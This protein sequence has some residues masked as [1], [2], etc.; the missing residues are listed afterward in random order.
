MKKYSPKTG[1][2]FPIGVGTYRLPYTGRK[3]DSPRDMVD[4]LPCSFSLKNDNG[5]MDVWTLKPWYTADGHTRRQ[6]KCKGV[7]IPGWRYERVLTYMPL[8][9]GQAENA[10][11]K[12]GMTSWALSRELRPSWSE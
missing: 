10:D 9:F 3:Y 1:W 2:E 4:D 8:E 12:A 6:V 11:W 5:G 7:S